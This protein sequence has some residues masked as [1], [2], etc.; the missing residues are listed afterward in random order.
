MIDDFEIIKWLN[1]NKYEVTCVDQ[2]CF[3]VF[4]LKRPSPND[5]LQLYSK[6][7]MVESKPFESVKEFILS[8]KKELIKKIYI[9]SF[10]KRYRFRKKSFDH[11]YFRFYID[12]VL[13]K[14][15]KFKERKSANCNV[16]T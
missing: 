16:L 12:E 11:K 1:D 4:L 7:C 5:N 15:Y 9:L 2:P 10:N 6:I 8:Y 3:E 13:N 14:R